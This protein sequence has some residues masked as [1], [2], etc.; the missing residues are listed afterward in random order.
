[1]NILRA[2]D[3]PKVFGPYFRA[4]SW[5]TWRVFLSA[6]FALPMTPEQLAIYQRHT[7][8]TAPP[9][10]PSHESW[11]CCGRRSG[12][13]FILATVAVFLAC[14]FD[15]RPHLG[16]GEMA[17][18]MIIA[19]DRRQARVI[20][21]FIVGLIKEVPMLQRVLLDET[22]E[23][24]TLK[25]QVSIEIH[26]A[27]FRSTRGYT[28]VAALLDELAFWPQGEDAAEPDS[29]VINAIRPGMS[30][31]SGSMMLCASS[32]YARRGA[33]WEAYR[34]H[35]GK[36]GDPVLVWQAP[37]RVMN[38]TVPQ[39][40]ISEAT[41]RDPASAA[42]EYGA[43][44]RTDIESFVSREVI[45]AAVVPGRYELPPVPGIA[46]VAFVDPSGGSADSMTL[47]VAHM[48]ADRV[49]ID[50]I[51]E[52]RPP[53]SPDDVVLEFCATLKSYGITTIRGDHYGGQWPAERFRIHGVRFEVADKAKSSLYQEMLPSL[54]SRR[55]ELLDNARLVAQLGSLERRVGRSGRDLID[56]PPG[57][58]D[59]IVNAV[60]GVV[61]ETLCCSGGMAAVPMHVWKRVL[62]DVSRYRYDPPPFSERQSVHFPL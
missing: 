50:A 27:S 19:K 29:E 45:D 1:M 40:I 8:R 61:A 9:S 59:D 2:I 11:L 31:I 17:T 53:F 48:Q 54:N 16:P 6:L 26:T 7:G 25:N 23:I 5:Q 47:A 3:D 57:T 4:A 24:V 36:D 43:E 22:A 41:E 46:Y 60:A 18:I 10:E 37:T 51:R 62:D 58:H 12:K 39:S 14:F 33:L 56:H 20:K 21:R 49:V 44:F 38:C 32:P 30:T 34:R 52:R 28:I 35:F 15:W 42:A 13:S 55:L